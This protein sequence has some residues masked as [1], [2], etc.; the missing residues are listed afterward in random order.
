MERHAD[1]FLSHL[2]QPS[3]ICV[4]RIFFGVHFFPQKVEELFLAVILTT[5]AK[6]AKLTTATLQVS[7]AYLPLT[8][9]PYKLRPKCFSALARTPSAPPGFARALDRFR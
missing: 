9:Y 5:Q 2:L 8:T 7:P 1:M 6:T 4:A 3:T